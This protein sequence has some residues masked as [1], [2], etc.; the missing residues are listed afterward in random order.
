[1]PYWC[2]IEVNLV[3]DLECMFQVKEDPWALS[4]RTMGPL[5]LYN[6]TYKPDQKITYF[7]KKQR[8]LI[9]ISI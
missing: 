4:G 9:G 7:M 2:P 3:S 6:E 1:M 5:G 8:I